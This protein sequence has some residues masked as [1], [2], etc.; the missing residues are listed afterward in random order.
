MILWCISFY[1]GLDKD[2]Y[3]YCKIFRRFIE[4]NTRPNLSERKRYIKYVIQN[5]NKPANK[6]IWKKLNFP[7]C[8]NESHRMR[9]QTYEREKILNSI[10]TETF[11][12]HS[13]NEQTNKQ[14]SKKLNNLNNY[15]INLPS[16]NTKNSEFNKSFQSVE[17]DSV[18]EQD[19]QNYIFLF[20]NSTK[21]GLCTKL[22]KDETKEIEIIN[23]E[24]NFESTNVKGRNLS[25][26]TETNFNGN[27][28]PSQQEA[29]NYFIKNKKELEAIKLIINYAKENNAPDFFTFKNMCIWASKKGYFN[30]VQEL[31]QICNHFYYKLLKE[32]CFFEHFLC[33]ALFQQ[34]RYKDALQHLNE[35]TNKYSYSSEVWETACFIMESINNVPEEIWPK[36][37]S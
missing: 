36:V 32:E 15:N 35:V 37:S 28:S 17:K 31:K 19:K 33:E 6:I 7:K 18:K 10:F 23:I 11:K 2:P 25:K 16:V 21:L 13:S 8:E 22:K 12:H 9:I 24:D 20:S 34:G 3:L 26:F 30:V 4:T 1:N 29:I 5:F 14:L 27:L